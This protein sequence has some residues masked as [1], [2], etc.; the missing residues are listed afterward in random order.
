MNLPLEISLVEPYREGDELPERMLVGVEISDDD[1]AA[2]VKSVPSHDAGVTSLVGTVLTSV[3]WRASQNVPGG[4]S[5]YNP[6]IQNSGVTKQLTMGTAYANNTSGG[7]DEPFSFQHPIAPGG[8]YTVNLNGMQDLFATTNVALARVKG[9]QVRLLSLAD[10]STINTNTNTT[11]KICVTNRIVSVPAPL[12]WGSGG[13]GLTLNI[14]NAAS[15]VINSVTINTAGSGYLANSTFGVSVNQING[16]AACIS[17]NTNA[18]GIPTAAVIA[19]G[20]TG[21]NTANGVPTTELGSFWLQTGN[22]QLYIDVTAGGSAISANSANILIQNMDA[23]HP[24]TPEI[25]TFGA[26]T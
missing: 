14:T 16:A 19:N 20:G 15:G 22:A 2:C 18:A 11:S 24:V 1:V 13:S 7:V 12:Y 6:N 5:A 8:S 21:Y 3:Q 25:T 26:T 4:G 9:F 23:T 17:I 10:D